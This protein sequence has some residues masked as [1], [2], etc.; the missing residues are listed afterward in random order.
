MSAT[1]DIS[2]TYCNPIPLPYYPLGRNCMIPEKH[3]RMDYRET[4]DP[5]VIYED[6]KWY[7]YPSCGMVYWTED[8]T[9]W[10][11]ERMEPYDCGYAPTVVKHR[12]K[13]YLTAC[14]ANVYVSESP[15]GPF[16]DIGPL[17]DAE[18]RTVRVDDPMLFSD[19]DGSLYLYCGC[20]GAIRGAQLDS[21]DPTRLI[22]PLEVMFSMDTENHVW[23]RMGD[24]NEDGSYSWIE[25]A[26]MYKR[27]GKYY[28]TYCG[29][30][31]EW[32]TYGMGAYTGDGP[33]G[34]W[35]YMD[36]SPFMSKRSGLVRGPGHGCIVDGPGGTVWAFYTCVMCYAGEFERRIGFDPIGFDDNG[37]IIPTGSSE[38]PQLVPGIMEKPWEENGAGLVPLTQHKRS[39]ASSFA[40]GRDAI[41]ATDDSM[42]SWWQPDLSDGRPTLTVKLGDAPLCIC[43]ARIIWRDVG[44]DIKKGV[45]A[46]PF[47]YMIEAR[48]GE[49]GQWVCVLDRSK[50]T[51]DLNIDYRALE[52]ME[53]TEV[54]LI[55]CSSPEGIEPGVIN[56]TV[57]GRWQ[58]EQADH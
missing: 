54:R 30:G 6:G 52:I 28:L 4:A 31:T 37:N 39:Q 9:V 1:F 40:P 25:G 12:G 15:L 38:I 42:L 21:E 56:F 20:G 36:T 50:N 57:F 19:D 7:L 14:S 34:P 43:S 45:L 26:W 48:N 5:S 58:A 24:W 8:F 3:T 51:V 10:H 47:C 46:G 23:E 18:G 41:Y 53:A 29:P 17:T 32:I 2:K 33:L 11:H 49:E 22:S 13:F 16:R 27:N 44:L 55:I 35:T